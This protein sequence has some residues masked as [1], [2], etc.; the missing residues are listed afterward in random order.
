MRPQRTA[1]S[2]EPGLALLLGAAACM[3]HPGGVSPEPSSPAARAGGIEEASP[4]H[5]LLSARLTHAHWDGQSD[6]V[7][8][9][10]FAQTV[11]PSTVIPGHFAVISEGGRRTVPARA[12]LIPANELDEHRSVVLFG[13]FTTTGE[14]VPLH[15]VVRGPV[16][17]TTGA[18][19]S[20]AGA[21]VEGETSPPRL[22]GAEVMEPAVGRC[23]GARQVVRTY[24]SNVL[25]GVEAD[26]RGRILVTMQSGGSFR[27]VGFDDHGTTA[28][29]IDENA[30][31]NVLDVC[32]D[33]PGVPAHLQ[34]DSGTFTDP[35]GH[36]SLAVV[37]T[38]E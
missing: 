3:A 34:V 21:S 18:P 20:P 17:A 2:A 23:N 35:E 27:P 33:N 24:W 22:V 28:D 32:V 36:P 12:L 37:M 5:R 8:L 38:L 16:F 15:V 30:E 13:D 25:R 4:G 9:L 1:R 6:P 19:L 31:D 14:R 7:I 26:D 11:D 29:A 10:V